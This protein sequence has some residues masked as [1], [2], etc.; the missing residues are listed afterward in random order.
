MSGFVGIGHN[1]PPAEPRPKDCRCHTCKRDI[2]HLGIMRHRAMHRDRGEDCKIT[3]ST[4][5]TYRYAYGS[6]SEAKE[7]AE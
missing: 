6:D 1:K 7:N 5:E 2:H 4:G 3:F